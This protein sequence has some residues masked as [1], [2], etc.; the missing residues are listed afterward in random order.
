MKKVIYGGLLLVLVGVGIMGCKK[1]HPKSTN[2]PPGYT[3]KDGRLHFSSSIEMHSFLETLSL[4]RKDKQLEELR[5]LEIKTLDVLY[6]DIFKAEENNM[7]IIYKGL[8]PSLGISDYE[9]MGIIYEHTTLFNENIEKGIIVKT[10]GNDGWGFELLVNNPGYSPVLN[11]NGEVL[12]A[13][14]LYQFKG[15]KLYLKKFPSE[16]LIAEVNF[17]SEEKAGSN[18]TQW[19][20][21][22]ITFDQWIY[23]NNT[24]RYRKKIWGAATTSGI[25]TPGGIINC[26]FYVDAKAENRVNGSWG[27]RVGYMPFFRYD[28]SWK[29]SYQAAPCTFCSSSTT[30]FALSGP[31]QSS[32]YSWHSS[33]DPYGQTNLLIRYFK[34][35]G[36]HTL[37]QPWVV[38]SALKVSYNSTLIVSGGANGFS[39]TL[40]W[41]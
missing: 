27:G 30:P 1:E 35:H 11:E 7:S 19:I 29:Y 21:N 40:S 15:Q 23:V 18:W 9:K 26:Y 41:E 12:V 34:P 28:I 25:N 5:K 14:T 39:H 8:D 10:K 22:P 32:P 17:S 37:P 24:Q 16:E 13:D 38:T 6:D 31:G 36:E 33:S 20:V 3:V 2:K 4:L